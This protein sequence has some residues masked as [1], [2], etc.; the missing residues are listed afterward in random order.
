LLEEEEPV[1]SSMHKIVEKS[2]SMERWAWLR[3]LYY[4]VEMVE[5]L[6]RKSADKRNHLLI[7]SLKELEKIDT[8]AQQR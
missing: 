3:V 8:K 7:I 5:C 4:Q 6:G 2:L 1:E